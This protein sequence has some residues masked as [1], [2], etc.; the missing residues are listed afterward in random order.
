[1]DAKLRAWWSQRQRL[2]GSADGM[3][4]REVLEQTGWA[5]SVAGASPYLALFARAGLR[6]AAVD[7][8]LAK[9]AIH[10]LPAARGCT[11]I[12]PASQYGL[13]LKAGEDFS[14]KT[15]IAIARKLGVTDTEIDKLKAAILKALAKEPLDPDALRTAVGSATRSLGPEGVKKGLA[16][17]LPLALGLLQSAGEIRRLPINGR[18]DQQ[19]Y[20]Y[21]LWKPNPLA[22]WKL[23]R[24]ASFTELAR[25]YYRWIGAASLAEFQWFSGLGVKASQAAVA[26]LKLVP[27]QGDLLALPEDRAAFEKFQP[28]KKP[29]YVL[30]GSLDN[31]SHLRRATGS[32]IAPE[33]AGHA[34]TS[35]GAL[36]DLPGDLKSHAILDH[37]RLVGLWH[38]D[39]ETDSIAWTSFVKRDRALEEAVKRTEA[40]IREDLGDAR[41]FSLDSA[42]SRAPQI[43]ALRKAA[44]KA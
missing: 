19:R 32:L 16:T 9:A 3:S 33:D 38:F 15:E 7:A 44:G 4:A 1:M 10:E 11:Y 42:K 21:A 14:A 8:E 22:K 41:T 12:V 24:G 6:R 26:P 37:G 13:A 28:P 27:L 2:D 35:N 18:I 20:K 43:A 31:V 17:T 25:E 29:H 23:D 30:T 36:L 34:L 5:R 39:P 40:F